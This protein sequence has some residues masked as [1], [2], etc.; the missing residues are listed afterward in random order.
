VMSM[1]ACHYA[2]IVSAVGGVSLL[3]KD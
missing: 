1:K 2:R 3:T